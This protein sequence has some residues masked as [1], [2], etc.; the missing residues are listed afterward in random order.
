MGSQKNVLV[1]DDEYY[2]CRSVQKILAAEDIKTEISTSGRDGI[3]KVQERGF[4]L[5]IV[6][7]QM[8]EVNGFEVVRTI[9]KIRPEMPVI[10]TSG[11]NTPQ[12]KEKAAENGAGDFIPKPFTPDEMLEV[13]SKFFNSEIPVC[14]D[15]ITATVEATVTA[16]PR[17]VSP[18][19]PKKVVAYMCPIPLDYADDVIS[20]EEQKKY[21]TKYSI[22]NKLDV[23]AFYEDV[24]PSE[25]ILQRPAIREILDKERDAGVLLVERVWCLSRKRTLLK[26]FLEILDSEGIKLQTATTMMDCVSQFARHWHKNKELPFYEPPEA[27]YPR[28]CNNTE[29]TPNRCES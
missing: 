10:V 21:I 25:D 6:D 7:V 3:A 15:Q 20:S 28:C 9:R 2:V 22:R 8:P 12:T 13:V 26:P 29:E 23:S 16:A 11:Y 27:Q 1:I 4:D 19:N 14:A 5:I 17:E 24:E 18:R